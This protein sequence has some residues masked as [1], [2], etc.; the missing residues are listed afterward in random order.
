MENKTGEQC[1]NPLIT[2]LIQIGISCDEWRIHFFCSR[3]FN[4]AIATTKLCP[5]FVKMS[6]YYTMLS[7]THRLA[8]TV[9]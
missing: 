4:S 5:M 2:I 9:G 3:Y 7:Y 1:V 6:K 8:D